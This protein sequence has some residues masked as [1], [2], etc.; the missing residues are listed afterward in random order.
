MV[1]GNHAIEPDGTVTTGCVQP[2]LGQDEKTPCCNFD[3][4]HPAVIALA[5]E[6]GQGR[7]N[8]APPLRTT[9]QILPLDHWHFGA[10]ACWGAAP[11]PLPTGYEPSALGR[12]LICRHATNYRIRTYNGTNAENRRWETTRGR[13]NGG[14]RFVKPTDY[15]SCLRLRRPARTDPRRSITPPS[16]SITSVEEPVK[17]TDRGDDAVTVEVFVAPA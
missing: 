16:P 5:C 1:P 12:A 3:V 4:P 8:S 2:R 17:A 11:P 10:E 13:P 15:A 7:V 9:S 6:R 14:F